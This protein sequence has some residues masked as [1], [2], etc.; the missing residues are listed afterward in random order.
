[1]EGL[2]PKPAGEVSIEVRFSFDLHGILTVTASETGSGR[3][4]Q[5]VV[6]NA[7]MHR[8]ASHELEQSRGSVETLFASLATAQEEEDGAEPDPEADPEAGAEA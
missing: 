3:H 4:E 6:N 2:P 1:V 8:L 5:L 7:S